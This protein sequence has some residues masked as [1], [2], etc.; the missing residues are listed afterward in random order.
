VSLAFSRDGHSLAAGTSA[1]L[2]QLIEVATAKERCQFKGHGANVYGVAFAPDGKTLASAS[3]DG[4]V[5][6]WDVTAPGTERP[7]AGGKL[8]A[9]QLESMWYVLAGNDAAAAYRVMNI[10]AAAP[11]QAVPFLEERAK[12]LSRSPARAPDPR[13]VAR[14]ITDLDDDDFAVREKATAELRKLGRFAEAALRKALQSDPSPEV[15]RRVEQLL[16]RL[17]DA[18]SPEELRLLRTAEVLERAGIPEARQLLK[19]LR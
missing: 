3:G 17:K 2:I 18:V 19:S 8:T 16:Q 1:S 11:A 5:K 10:L 6:L 15:Q 7:P 14:L 9:V 13:H 4:T 12:P